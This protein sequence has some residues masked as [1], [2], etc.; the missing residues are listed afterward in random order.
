MKF[1]FISEGGG[2]LLGAGA[3]GRAGRAPLRVRHHERGDA[4][5]RVGAGDQGGPGQGR[6]GEGVQRQGARAEHAQVRHH[7]HP[8]SR[9]QAGR[10]EMSL[11]CILQYANT[12]VGDSKNFSFIGNE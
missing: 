4:D 5:G 7:R 8:V 2:A 6:R 3:G 1:S 10:S 9:S 12:K 11:P